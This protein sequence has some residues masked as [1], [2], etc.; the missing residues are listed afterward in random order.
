MTLALEM[1]RKYAEGR[2]QSVKDMINAGLTTFAAVK[3]S[4]IYTENEL[5][6]IVEQITEIGKKNSLI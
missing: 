2:I 4:G 1:D 5:A 3:Q 6:A